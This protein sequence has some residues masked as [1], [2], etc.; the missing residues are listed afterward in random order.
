MN[1]EAVPSKEELRRQ[2][3]LILKNHSE[4]ARM[5]ASAEAVERLRRQTIWL[6][7]AT[8]LFYS[9]ISGEL[10]LSVLMAAALDSGKTV[11]LPRFA[12]ESGTY[13]AVHITD[14][15]RDCASGK[16]GILEP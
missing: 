14:V 1:S 3:R 10:D 2:L 8:V 9:A 4:A 11:L 12:K 6:K 7:A 13:E 5:Q 15:K 16:F